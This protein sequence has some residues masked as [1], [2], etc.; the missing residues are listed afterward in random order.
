GPRAVSALCDVEPMVVQLPA[1]LRLDRRAARV[2]QPC[3]YPE[4]GFD[5]VAIEGDRALELRPAASDAIDRV[6]DRAAERGWG[7]LELPAR[8]TL[9]DDPEVAAHLAALAERLVARKARV[10]AQWPPEL[11]GG[12]PLDPSCIAVA[13]SHRDQRERVR[14]ALAGGPAEGAVVDTANRLQGR[15]FDVVL[16]WHPLSGRVEA[17]EFHLDTGRLC[18]M[19]SR[20]RQACIF[21]CR[22]G[23]PELLDEHLP[24]GAR[25]K[26]AHDD[27]EHD[28]WLAHRQLFELLA[29]TTVPVR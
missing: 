20:H 29:D 15:E 25:P 21:V 4:L 24:S 5:A 13:T 17:S 27:R 22:A 12:A 7:I 1:S 19:A 3:F 11:R 9:R 10:R 18:V 6:L 23:V 16:V 8:I 14:E 2:V 28:G 26:G